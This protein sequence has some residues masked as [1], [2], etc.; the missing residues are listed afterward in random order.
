MFGRRGSPSSP[1]SSPPWRSAP[2]AVAAA[3]SWTSSLAQYWHNG[4]QDNVLCGTY[5]DCDQDAR[6]VG[7]QLIRTEGYTLPPPSPGPL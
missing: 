6:A 2:S 7:Y 3:A 5:H 1:C 4:R